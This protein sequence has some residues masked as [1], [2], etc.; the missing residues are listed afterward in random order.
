MS[1]MISIAQASEMT[2]VEEASAFIRAA[3]ENDTPLRLINSSKCLKSKFSD[4]RKPFK[5][6]ASFE[7]IHELD[8]DA[9]ESLPAEEAIDESPKLELIVDELVKLNSYD[10]STEQMHVIAKD[11]GV[12]KEL[13]SE[14]D[15]DWRILALA[16]VT[17]KEESEIVARVFFF[18]FDLRLT[19]NLGCS[20]RHLQSK[21]R[22]LGSTRFTFV[23]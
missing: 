21:S 7:I 2:A 11:L 5:F 22:R 15:G 16:A 18:Q 10:L 4:F 13:V 6:G 14:A 3:I 9:A 23:S 17:R 19:V 1:D 12:K 20:R 8:V